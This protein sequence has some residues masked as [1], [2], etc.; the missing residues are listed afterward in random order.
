MT[1]L[2]SFIH[3]QP[4]LFVVRV[5]KKVDIDK[6]THLTLRDDK[7]D[8]D[9]DTHIRDDDDDDDDSLCDDNGDVA[10]VLSSDIIKLTES[11]LLYRCTP[12]QNTIPTWMSPG[13]VNA[14]L[15]PAQVDP[16]ISVYSPSWPQF[17]PETSPRP[18][19]LLNLIT[20]SVPMSFGTPPLTPNA[21]AYMHDTPT[22]SENSSENS[23]PMVTPTSTPIKSPTSPLS[24]E[25]A[26]P[27]LNTK[28][29]T[30]QSLSSLVSTQTQYKSPQTY[31]SN[32]PT[33]SQS[34]IH[35][36]TPNNTQTH[37][38]YESFDLINFAKDKLT[39]GEGRIHTT[40]RRPD[41]K[42]RSGGGIR[43][44]TDIPPILPEVPKYVRTYSEDHPSRI[45]ENEK[46][47]Q[48]KEEKEEKEQ[49]E[50][51][52]EKEEKKKKEKKERKKERKIR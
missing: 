12:T 17:S 1:G 15:S 5:A 19:Q 42:G 21:T 41:R 48:E 10:F 43:E 4:L 38:L 24:P 33:L 22:S 52:E 36:I 44:R 31:A 11:P 16:L 40:Q 14:A 32:A 7:V 45:S 6:Y 28:K 37:S 30:S 2:Y 39:E 29:R 8:V 25:S 27:E 26:P 46:S 51:K 20:P 23:Y 49:K 50:E 3:C 35:M 18:P 47:K 34:V 13:A 9:K